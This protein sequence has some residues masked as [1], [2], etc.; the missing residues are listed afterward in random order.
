MTTTERAPMH[1]IAFPI[2]AAMGD[3]WAAD[4]TTEHMDEMTLTGPQGERLRLRRAGSHHSGAAGRRMSVHGMLPHDLLPH[5]HTADENPTIGVDSTRPAEQLARDIARRVLP[6]YHAA[7]QAARCRQVEAYAHAR[8]REDRADRVAALIG[9]TVSTPDSRGNVYVRVGSRHRD[10][11]E[12]RFE[13]RADPGR[14]VDVTLTLPPA[15][16][17][18]LAELLGPLLRDY[19]PA[20]GAVMCEA[21]GA[22]WYGLRAAGCDP[23]CAVCGA[24]V[25]CA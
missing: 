2:A 8:I 16:A 4:V 7:R 23:I 21:C 12:A 20:P 17:M 24:R 10:E 19:R 18:R 11:P 14:D 22:R 3:G 6:G 9:A 5:S 15:A 13:L 25:P 1:R